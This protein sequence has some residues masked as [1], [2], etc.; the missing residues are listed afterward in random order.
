MKHSPRRCAS[1][2]LE[3]PILVDAQ[4]TITPFAGTDDAAS[5]TQ[6]AGDAIGGTW[7]RFG[8]IE[9]ATGFRVCSQQARAHSVKARADAMGAHAQMTNDQRGLGTTLGTAT[10]RVYPLHHH[11][12]HL[13]VPAGNGG[14]TD[15]AVPAS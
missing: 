14:V 1:Q 12:L 7:W 13:V 6:W 2:V 8:K 3:M 15:A 9:S 4:T 10:R 11:L 5:V